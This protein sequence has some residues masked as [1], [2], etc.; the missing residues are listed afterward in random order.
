MASL[1]TH[2]ADELTETALDVLRPLL[3]P[4]TEFI[5]YERARASSSGGEHS[6]G[7]ADCRSHDVRRV[8]GLPVM[9]GWNPQIQ[10]VQFARFL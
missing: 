2:E 4:D 9:F 8:V 5:A 3:A 6:A 10:L 7:A 1:S